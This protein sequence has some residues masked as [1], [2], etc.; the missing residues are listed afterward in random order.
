MLYSFELSIAYILFSSSLVLLSH[1]AIK[2]DL[3][4]WSKY[5]FILNRD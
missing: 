5:Q 1:I 3:S 2:Y 4:F